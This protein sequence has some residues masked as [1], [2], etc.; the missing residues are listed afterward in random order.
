MRTDNEKRNT[1]AIQNPFGNRTISGIKYRARAMMGRCQGG[2]CLPKIIEILRKDFGLQAEDF[3]L[4]RP[5]A[6]LF[7][8]EAMAKL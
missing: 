5:E 7:S 4:N 1:N 6:N 3:I 2:F 8:G